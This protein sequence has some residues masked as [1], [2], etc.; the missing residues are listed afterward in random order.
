MNLDLSVT[1]MS[2]QLLKA[3]SPAPFD[4][5]CADLDDGS[6]RYYSLD[7]FRRL[8]NDAVES[9]RAYEELA[10]TLELQLELCRDRNSELEHSLMEY[11]DMVNCP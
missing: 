10:G 2:H 5:L 4:D 11:A 9:M 6:Y 1:S 7:Q 3:L 8:Y